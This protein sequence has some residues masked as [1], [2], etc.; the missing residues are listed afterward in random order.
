MLRRLSI[1]LVCSVLVQ[2]AWDQSK[3]DCCDEYTLRAYAGEL[4]RH[5]F[6]AA[7]LREKEDVII[8]EAFD[9]SPFVP[10]EALQILC[11]SALCRSS[12]LRYWAR[13]RGCSESSKW[14]R[15]GFAWAAAKVRCMRLSQ[16][17]D[18][19]QQYQVL[20]QATFSCERSQAM[21][22][23]SLEATSAAIKE[24]LLQSMSS[25]LDSE[26]L[27]VQ[28]AMAAYGAPIGRPL[29]FQLATPQKTKCPKVVTT[30]PWDGE[31]KVK[32]DLEYFVLHFDRCVRLQMEH[33]ATLFGRGSAAERN[34]SRRLSS[35]EGFKH[36]ALSDEVC[37]EEVISASLPVSE[38]QMPG[39]TLIFKPDHPLTAGCCYRFH[40]DMEAA[41]SCNSQTAL[42]EDLKIDFCVEWPPPQPAVRLEDDRLLEISFSVAV[43]LNASNERILLEAGPEEG[44]GEVVKA[45][46][47]LQASKRLFWQLEYGNLTHQEVKDNDDGTG[48][49]MGDQVY[50]AYAKYGQE[51]R[52]QP[53]ND[54]RSFEVDLCTEIGNCPDGQQLPCGMIL[55][56]VFPQGL[57]ISE[58]VHSLQTT[59]VR[60]TR[61]CD[62][63]QLLNSLRLSNDGRTLFFSWSLPALV[64]DPMAAISL[65]RGDQPSAQCLLEGVPI[66][67]Q[68]VIPCITGPD[69]CTE[70]SLDVT[71]AGKDACGQLSLRVE[72][73]A[74]R[75]VRN[76]HITSHESLASVSHPIPCGSFDEPSR[77]KCLELN[78][79]VVL[80][81]GQS[82]LNFQVDLRGGHIDVV[83]ADSRSSFL[84]GLRKGAKDTPCAII[85]KVAMKFW[86]GAE[87]VLYEY[88]RQGGQLYVTGG[89]HN[90]EILRDVFGLDVQHGHS[91]NVQHLQKLDAKGNSVSGPSFSQLQQCSSHW[92]R[93]LPVLNAMSSVKF[94]SL[95]ANHFSHEVAAIGMYSAEET[96]AEANSFSVVEVTV[97]TGLM[98]YFAFDWYENL[99]EDRRPWAMQLALLAE[100]NAKRRSAQSFLGASQSVGGP[101]ASAAEAYRPAAKYTESAQTGSQ[102][103][104]SGSSQPYRRPSKY[105]E[106][107]QS[108]GHFHFGPAGQQ[109]AWQPG[110]S[111]PRRLEALD[112][113]K[114]ASPLTGDPVEPDLEVSIAV[115]CDAGERAANCDGLRDEM[116]QTLLTPDSDFYTSLADNGMKLDLSHFAPPH[117]I[118]V[119]SECP[120]LQRIEDAV[121][122]MNAACGFRA[123][124][125]SKFSG[126]TAFLREHVIQSRLGVEVLTEKLRK[127]VCH[128]PVCRGHVL[129]LHKLLAGCGEG[130]GHK[131]VI[132]RIVTAVDTSIDSCLEV[133][134]A[135]QGDA[136]HSEVASAG[137]AVGV[138]SSDMSE[139]NHVL[140]KGIDT[141]SQAEMRA[142]ED[143]VS[144]ILAE[145][146]QLPM[147]AFEERGGSFAD[148]FDPLLGG[149]NVLAVGDANLRVA[150]SITPIQSSEPFDEAVGIFEQIEE[151]NTPVRQNPEFNNQHNLQM[152]AIQPE[153]N[154]QDVDPS[155]AR[156][157]II[158]E[159]IVAKDDLSAI[160]RIIPAA[161]KDVCL[162]QELD[163]DDT[164]QWQMFPHDTGLGSLRPASVGVSTDAV[165]GVPIGFFCHKITVGDDARV[166]A[167]GEVLQIELDHP[168]LRN[169]EYV[170]LL[171]PRVVKAAMGSTKFPGALWDGWPNE[172][173]QGNQ[174]YVFTTGVPRASNARL[175]IAVSCSSEKECDR[176]RALVSEQGMQDLSSRALCFAAWF[177]CSQDPIS[178]KHCE[179][180]H[181]M[182]WCNV[183][184]N[185]APSWAPASHREEDVQLSGVPDQAVSEVQSI[186]LPSWVYIIALACWVQGTFA[187]LRAAWWVSDSYTQS[188][189]FDPYIAQ[190]LRSLPIK[191]CAV[192]MAIPFLTG[193]LGALMA[194]P[195][196]RITVHN[197]W[198]HGAGSA[199]ALADVSRLHHQ[200]ATA[201][202]AAFCASEAITVVFAYCLIA[203]FKNWAADKGQKV[204]ISALCC[205]AAGAAGSA[206]GWVGASDFR[207]M[208]N[209][210]LGL[211]WDLVVLLASAGFAQL[212]SL[213]LVPTAIFMVLCEM[214]GIGDI[215]THAVKFQFFQWQEWWFGRSA[216]SGVWSQLVL[217]VA[218]IE[219]DE[220]FISEML[221]MGMDDGHL[222]LKFYCPDTPHDVS[223][224]R[225]HA[226]RWGGDNHVP[227]KFDGEDIFVNFTDPFTL[228]RVDVMFQEETSTRP[229]CVATT[230]WDPWCAALLEKFFHNSELCSS[231]AID[232]DFWN[233]KD[234]FYPDGR[235]KHGV[236]LK[237][238]LN[239]TRHR[240]ECAPEMGV[241]R[242]HATHMGGFGGTRRTRTEPWTKPEKS[243]TLGDTIHRDWIL[244][245]RHIVEVEKNDFT[246][247]R[248]RR[249]P[250]EEEEERRQLAH[251]H[252]H[253]HQG[254]HESSPHSANSFATLQG[255][256]EG[257]G[258][259][260]YVSIRPT[261]DDFI[262]Q[263]ISPRSGR[264]PART[265][266]PG[267]DASPNGHGDWLNDTLESIG[268]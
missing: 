110:E 217:L 5:C 94:S 63:P 190:G 230:T 131:S 193:L 114:A 172:E 216:G 162:R 133:H 157:R 124:H 206:C 86:N 155:F 89:H 179:A 81:P 80:E 178:Q 52:G 158:F 87:R 17:Q 149:P 244:R 246:D 41:G 121:L 242:F 199:N 18:P 136:T 22:S 13:V 249:D 151:K 33:S 129:R 154:Q 61:P 64:A 92:L 115:A 170:V 204:A 250:A 54:H 1:V 262:Q 51:A 239:L 36:P 234:V 60:Y 7:L 198:R 161:L 120:S 186:S 236:F 247:G 265:L 50:C 165:Q 176:Q 127:Q 75:A 189:D 12:V 53:C 212:L 264:S 233:P 140:V 241:L 268:L 62:P 148:I 183:H 73:G 185:W 23:G 128:R 227:Q 182:S 261:S 252:Q 108:D 169:T 118:K 57:A 70:W 98:E 102:E 253:S 263:R 100:C 42:C 219:I 200:L 195:L 213:T 11:A 214:P 160:I 49:S 222:F 257:R 2:G 221:N 76:E 8:G 55:N 173:G 196:F 235:P 184:G 44:G 47:L 143:A 201:F 232:G 259:P 150:A 245:R 38:A 14:K 251:R 43:E 112:A 40:L 238:E 188:R 107:A 9:G 248:F 220:G 77:P 132:A 3:C 260:Q 141:G 255:N 69:S 79:P 166:L 29:R 103:V 209:P 83:T 66:S 35:V 174:E 95:R 218:D 25:S 78:D 97:G 226:V 27:R 126:S 175:S 243:M 208:T 4:N 142:V 109:P 106:N 67:D 88:V 32:S 135:T 138:W 30:F 144:R 28:L 20:M 139:V 21:D 181:D 163:V 119:L 177:R 156:I 210:S 231:N 68:R 258:R 39:R 15:Y 229:E 101:Q 46:H 6:P 96:F 90:R 147:F 85:P 104:V 153:W 113:W 137:S 123:S 91:G 16:E 194:V 211:A 26:D 125:E 84:G 159:D 202:A 266:E 71:D 197:L 145:D 37:A 19:I 237:L 215:L 93:E 240:T 56:V 207:Q 203:Y 48:T 187:T 225:S 74:V 34:A 45:W 72:E 267:R 180:P 167:S 31:I 105:A 171:P 146:L 152:L 116:L 224:T 82:N 192:A 65:C 228:L 256:A 111:Q 99:Q 205:A 10:Q 130:S 223:L 164:F 168:L 191:A 24:A 117:V 59:I 122:T 134:S 58:G 254:E